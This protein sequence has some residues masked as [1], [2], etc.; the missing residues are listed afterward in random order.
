MRF[1]ALTQH[2]QL[3]L[4][5]VRLLLPPVIKQLT[6]GV[7]RDG[8]QEEPDG[9]EE[10]DQMKPGQLPRDD[11]DAHRDQQQHQSDAACD[12]SDFQAID[13]H[14]LHTGKGHVGWVAP[15]I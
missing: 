3:T 2:E 7:A 15:T 1:T 10:Q 14:G 8:A 5:K 4:G 6:A 11:V 13:L 9:E 12:E